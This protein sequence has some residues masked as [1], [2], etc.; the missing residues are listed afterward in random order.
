MGA[1]AM[2]KINY[3]LND[4]DDI[5]FYEYHLKTSSTGKKTLLRYRLQ[6][7]FFCL[8]ILLIFCIA[9][10]DSVVI[11]SEAVFML[12]VSIIW[13]VFADKIFFRSF[14]KNINKIRKE[15]KV[16]YSNEGTL[17]FDEEFF[18]DINPKTE[19]KTLYSGVEKIVVTEKAIYI[20]I[21]AA[22]AHIIPITCFGSE[23]EKQN[24]L[25]FITSKV[26]LK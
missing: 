7:P 25:N 5:A 24:F 15:G 9:K 22:Q 12:V 10:L 11:I 14:K 26:K 13:I 23:E 20:Y 2:Y 19:T 18:K 3:K 4:D 21:G 6:I 17:V 8:L 1:I 16:P